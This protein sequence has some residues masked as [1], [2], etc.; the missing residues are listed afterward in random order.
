MARRALATTALV[1]SLLPIM[2]AVLIFACCVLPLHNVV[3]RIAPAC[4]GAAGLVSETAGVDATDSVPTR[5]PEVKRLL[6]IFKGIVR[7]LPTA[8]AASLLGGQL[9]S[10]SM[11]VQRV[12][13]RNAISL[14]ALRVDDDVGPQSLLSTYRI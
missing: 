7:G 6:E 4:H 9:A 12:A 14:G 11:T 5:R 8:S 10:H 1:A 13:P 2:G 3:H